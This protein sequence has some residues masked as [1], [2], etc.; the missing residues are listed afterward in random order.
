MGDI[1][2]AIK[3]CSGVI[4]L[5]SGVG[6]EA[7]TYRKPVFTFAEAD[8]SM[9]THTVKDISI[10]EWCHKL[11]K[12]NTFS[13]FNEYLKYNIFLTDQDDARIKVSRIIKDA[14]KTKSSEIKFGY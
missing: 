8:Y 9:V 11:P 4:I 7:L 2:E 12:K 3:R 14:L 10:E 5:N 1:T 13:F 6:F